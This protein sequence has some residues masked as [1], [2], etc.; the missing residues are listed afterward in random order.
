MPVLR[1]ISSA[2]GAQNKLD[3]MVATLNSCAESLD[4]QACPL[5][6]V[7]RHKT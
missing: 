2:A 4:K 1:A 6:I 3:I 5:S 7:Q